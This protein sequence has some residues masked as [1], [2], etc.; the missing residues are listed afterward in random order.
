VQVDENVSPTVPPSRRLNRISVMVAVA[1]VEEF[2]V[3]TP[4]NVRPAP[5]LS[6]KNADAPAPKAVRNDW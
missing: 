2:T 3:Q 5:S 1:G 4:P 6:M